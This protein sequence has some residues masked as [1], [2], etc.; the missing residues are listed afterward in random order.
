MLMLSN[1]FF[2]DNINIG[3]NIIKCLKESVDT[4]HLYV[5]IIKCFYMLQGFHFRFLI[6]GGMVLPPKGGDSRGGTPSLRGGNS[7]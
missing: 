6:G 3:D 1:V 4:N 7:A 2:F 5:D